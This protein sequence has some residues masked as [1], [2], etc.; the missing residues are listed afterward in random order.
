L[1]RALH[2]EAAMVH[3]DPSALHEI[4]GRTRRPGSSRRSWV[5]A[6]IGAAAATAAVI[7][8]V[9]I[10]GDRSEH[11]G[12]GPA[13][14]GS[15]GAVQQAMH[16]GV[17]DPTAADALQVTMAYFD[18]DQFDGYGIPRL[19]SEPHTIGAHTDSDERAA[20]HEFLTSRPID[21]DYTSG[22]PEGVDVDTVTFAG[23]VMHVALTGTAD[24]GTTPVSGPCPARAKSAV[25]ALIQSSGTDAP[26]Q[27][28][29]NGDPVDTLFG[30]VDVAGGVSSL[31]EDRV[32]ALLSIDNLVDGQ[33]VSSPVTVTVSG[34]VFEGT[35]NW[36]LLDDSGAK[37]DEGVVTTSMGTW[38]Q[39]PID[40]GNLD[41]GTYT[42]RCLELSP[43]DGKPGNIDDKTFTVE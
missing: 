6:G 8:G 41:P 4:Q 12:A 42:I 10:A 25:Q 38:T 9:T 43:K 33:T 21:P 34:N 20:V 39:A 3:T 37:L 18:L 11:Q 32:R 29:Y 2:E 26:T 23:D 28:T 17:Y 13:N 31:P 40:L 36:Q 16:D 27:F 5:Y 19:Y 14:H 7:A 24:L 35:I 30:C 15:N 22:W 1:T